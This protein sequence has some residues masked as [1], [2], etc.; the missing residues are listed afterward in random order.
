MATAAAYSLYLQ[1]RFDEALATLGEID[2]AELGAPERAAYLGQLLAAAGPVD[3]AEGALNMALAQPNL[4]AAQQAGIERAL[5]L[6]AY[7]WAMGDWLHGT[8]AA[9]GRARDFFAT[10]AL[11]GKAV[12][13]MGQSVVLAAD[14][15]SAAAVLARIEPSGLNGAEVLLYEGAVLNLV[16][17]K[18]AAAPLLEL[19]AGMPTETTGAHWHR[20]VDA[21]WQLVDRKPFDDSLA[22]GLLAAYRGLEAQETNAAFWRDD[23]ARELRLTRC[24]ASL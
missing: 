1:G 17:Q 8:D 2:P 24:G 5:D 3:R 16:G 18:G 4:L 19:E 11:S 12:F 23:A 15:A 9:R 6:V 10:R 14:P 7:R 22:G 13:L 20:S 21:W